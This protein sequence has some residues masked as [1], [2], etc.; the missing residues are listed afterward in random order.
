MSK[1]KTIVIT[2]IATLGT[3]GAG[4]TAVA[5]IPSV[6]KNVSVSV[7]DKVV[8]GSEQNSENENLKAELNSEKEKVAEL[9]A[10]KTKNEKTI[11]DLTTSNTELQTQVDSLTSEVNQK[12]EIVTNLENEISAKN[13]EIQ[14]KQEAVNSLNSQIEAN[15]AR[16][17]ELEEQGLSDSEE[18]ANLTSAN[19]SLNSQ[20]SSLNNEIS[21]LNSD[22]EAL[23]TQISS[24]NADIQGKETEI[25]N[26]NAT[27]STQ[28]TQISNLNNQ[29]ASLTSQITEKDNRIAEL[30]E[31]LNNTSGESWEEGLESRNLV[32]V[33][34]YDG[35]NLK[36]VIQDKGSLVDFDLAPVLEGYTFIGYAEE[37]AT[38]LT[39]TVEPNIDLYPVYIADTT[40]VTFNNAVETE[41]FIYNSTTHALD[42]T[43]I[44]PYVL[45]TYNE[46]EVQLIGYAETE[47]SIEA[48]KEFSSDKTYYGIY[49]VPSE[50][51][52]YSAKDMIYQ[53]KVY[54]NGGFDVA[55]SKNGACDYLE[56]SELASYTDSFTVDNTTFTFKGFASSGDSTEILTDLTAEGL[57]DIKILYVVYTTGTKDFTNNEIINMLSSPV[58][59]R[60]RY[61]KSDG[62][63]VVTSNSEIYYL[64]AYEFDFTFNDI[65]F[66]F[67]GWAKT[68]VTTPMETP[69]AGSNGYLYAI[70]EDKETG[71][72]YNAM[73]YGYY[74]YVENDSIIRG[75][76]WFK[77]SYENPVVI[78][79]VTYNFYGWSKTATGTTVTSQSYTGYAVYQNSETEEL[80][81]CGELDT[82]SLYY[83]DNL[84]EITSKTLNTSTIEVQETIIINEVTYTFAGFSSSSSSTTIEDLATTTATK[85]YAVYTDSEG[86]SKTYTEIQELVDTYGITVPEY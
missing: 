62:S 4:L 19:N 35:T 47:D 81:N 77:S 1:L 85:L 55:V 65:Q 37:N 33:N 25:N 58:A 26:L 21:T 41:T 23:N 51:K 70:Y 63:L 83:F 39:L 17:A 24:L 15:N 22:K 12:Q 53:Y 31:E 74:Y 18:I 28:E 34:Y 57:G 45:G 72:R 68:G 66:T 69:V 56:Y 6:K 73:S 27:I 80:I 8:Y 29:V 46:V 86:T 76:S 11:N 44:M 7:K 14:E 36:L 38:T 3:L 9:T 43:F 42:S 2:G 54:M 78:D 10:T 50:N 75:I 79:G 20:V 40:S 61:V 71:D 59:T 30:E 84:G 82:Y 48:V 16:I 60:L 13:S 64:K 67:L 52:I 5:L 49:Y 32:A